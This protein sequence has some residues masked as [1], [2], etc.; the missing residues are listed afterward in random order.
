[1]GT[2]WERRGMCE[3]ALKGINTA[4]NMLIAKQ[5]VSREV[6]NSKICNTKTDR[7]YSGTEQ[8]LAG[9]ELKFSEG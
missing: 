7:R 6:V 1:M 5:L 3:S 8:Q 2:A 4:T 9:Q